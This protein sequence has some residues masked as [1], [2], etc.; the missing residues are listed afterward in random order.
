MKA[1][2]LILL[3]AGAGLAQT[4][5]TLSGKIADAI[6]HRPIPNARV[7]YCCPRAV[8]TADDNGAYSLD[9]S[10]DG[11]PGTVTVDTPS[12]AFAP[13][14]IPLNLRPG[15]SEER[16]FELMPSARISGHVLDRDTGKPLAGFM[17][18]AQGKKG[19]AGSVALAFPS[20]ANGSFSFSGALA[21]GEY[22]LRIIPARGA[23]QAERGYGQSWYP[24]VPR[25]EMAAPITV[26]AG[27]HREIEVRL[28]KRELFHI[29]GSIEVPKAWEN[30][31]IT[32]ALIPGSSQKI[33]AAGP[34]LIE[35]LSEGSYVLFA[36]TNAQPG[37]D[38]AY[39]G[40]TI[41]ATDHDIDDL[42]LV[43][44]PGVAVQA[45]V[46][47]AEETVAQPSDIAFSAVPL[48]LPKAQRQAS[49]LRIEDMVPGEYWP[50]LTLPAGYA[51]ASVAFHGRPVDNTPIGLDARESVLEYIVTS[52]PAS[53]TGT[54]R[55]ANR[56]PVGDA[57]VVLVP[58]GDVE[59]IDP[60]TRRKTVSDASGQ[61]RFVDLGP[62][63]YRVSVSGQ[64]SGESVDLGLGRT[65][66]VELLR[67]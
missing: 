30:H 44:Q 67:K 27:E 54:V 7:V 4:A 21:E 66:S 49:P 22:T 15:A 52:R 36:A 8:I 33:P 39:V 5:A 59:K 41:E 38:H 45:T 62:G 34:F 56:N 2:V 26:T 55:D 12:P 47:M 37:E 64:N 3:F 14:R 24:G 25:E 13:L 18:M 57:T 48:L 40:Q 63:R 23:I 32:I 28:R 10:P 65:A 31:P 16:S 46:K 43:M 53:V 29:A 1:A 20:D 17:V 35:E 60:L 6:T 50:R 61:Y 51:V 11:S 42:K 9:A 19:A 58:E